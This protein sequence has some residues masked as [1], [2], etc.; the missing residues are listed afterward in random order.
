MRFVGVSD[1]AIG[2][3]MRKRWWSGF[4]VGS[5]L[6]VALVLAFEATR[7]ST[8]GLLLL[9]A[10]LLTIVCAVLG[11]W[12]GWGRGVEEYSDAGSR[13]NPYCVHYVPPRPFIGGLASGYATLC[14]AL[15]VVLIV[16]TVIRDW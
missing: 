12:G 9:A 14:A 13:G 16:S 5:L 8:G 7:E 3:S 15:L 2:N 4:A 6:F 1:Q 11:P 10:F